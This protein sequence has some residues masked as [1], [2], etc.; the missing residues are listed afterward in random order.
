MLRHALLVVLAVS[1]LVLLRSVLFERWL[2]VIACAGLFAGAFAVMR[3]RTGGALL[4]LA[5]GAA[6]GAAA[7]LSMGPSWFVLVT[8]A[9]AGP[10]VVLSPHMFRF[11]RLAATAALTLALL[12]GAGSAV[13]VRLAGDHVEPPRVV[14]MCR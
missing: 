13:A 2:T 11:D 7:A 14:R 12:W 9:A 1:T 8:L 10:A 3:G 4:L 6:F 5:L